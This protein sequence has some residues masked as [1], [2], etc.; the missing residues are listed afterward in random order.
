MPTTKKNKDILALVFSIISFFVPF[1]LIIAIIT[2]IYSNRSIRVEVTSIN[3]TTKVLSIISIICSVLVI[4]SAIV[5]VITFY[6]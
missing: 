2:L 4:I 3:K 6:S 5:G 1:G